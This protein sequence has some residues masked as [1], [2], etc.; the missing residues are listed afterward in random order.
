MLQVKDSMTREVVALSPE[1]TAK[2]ALALCREKRIRHLPVLEEA[3]A[4]AVGAVRQWPG[5]GVD[6]VRFV[7][8][9]DSTLQCYLATLRDE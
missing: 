7:C 2:A 3:T 1:D 9:D 6:L 4:V 8:F 5:E